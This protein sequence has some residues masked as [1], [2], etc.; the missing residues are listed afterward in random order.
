M[1]TFRG[2]ALKLASVVL[3]IIMA[4]L[5]KATATVV[6]A[7]EAVFFR[8]F[9]AMPVIVVWLVMRHDL[10]T[11]FIAQ[12]PL[13]HL[14]R[15]AAGVAA[16]GTSF[17]AL[18]LLPLPEVT[19][20]GYAAPLLTVLLAAALLGER[21]RAFRLTAVGIG[22]LGVLVILWPRLTLAGVNRAAAI[23]VAL[24]LVSSVLRALAQVQIRRLVATE[25]TSAIVFYFSLS[26][27]VM[28]LATLPFGWVVPTRA[29]AVMLILAG[30][31]GGLAQIL[32]T[33]AYRHAEAALLAPFDYAS[34]LFAL[35]IGYAV[36]AEVPTPAML[37]G[38]AIVIS[39]GVLIIWRERRLGL[40]RDKDRRTLTPQG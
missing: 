39:A 10:S 36:F 24:V 11:G 7:G 27:T 13:G 20:I 5:I 2:V 28:S 15:G 19:A 25:T 6:P 29:E 34:M 4:S 38:A 8:S 40:R 1:S 31:I 30:L 18:G 17:A 22:L 33:S 3:F 26:A 21:L 14:L 16:M 32:L 35:L 12:D 37:L 9:F 23:G